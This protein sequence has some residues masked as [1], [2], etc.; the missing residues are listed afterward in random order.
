MKKFVIMIFVISCLLVLASFSSHAQEKDVIL[1]DKTGIPDKGLYQAILE[2]L[3]KKG[4]VFTESEAAKII[5]LD[6]HNYQDQRTNIKSLKGIGYLKSLTSIDISANKLTSLTG[7]EELTKLEDLAAADNKIKNLKVIKDLTRLERLDVSANKITALSGIEKL[8]NLKYLRVEENKLTTLIEIKNLRKLTSL[9]VGFNRLK[10][11]AG[12]EE[13]TNLIFFDASNN[14]LHDIK[15]VENLITLA[16]LGVNHNK[17]ER[18]PDLTKLIDLSD[19]N[20]SFKFNK[21]PADELA[22]KLPLQLVN[23]SRWFKPQIQ[24]QRYNFT[25]KLTLHK[26][27]SFKRITVKTKKIYGTAQK[28]AKVRIKYKNKKISTV[29]ANANGSFKFKSLD[30]Q[31][32]KGKMLTMEVLYGGRSIIKSKKFTVRKV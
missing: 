22:S 17:L 13:L 16:G 11:L 10:N 1:N 24:L 26:P 28:N 7:I 32:Y 12:V 31:K 27:G 8:T 5:V 18:I 6:A 4:K 20:T 25:K 3:G 9:Y 19:K 15:G 2:Q 29:K 14:K 30:L 21:I 23:D